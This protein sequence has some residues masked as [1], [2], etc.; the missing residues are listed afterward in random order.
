LQS[1]IWDLPLST[2]GEYSNPFI[3]EMVAL[4]ACITGSKTR[5]R[6]E[7]EGGEKV[8]EK[9]TREQVVRGLGTTKVVAWVVITCIFWI[10]IDLS[11]DSF[12]HLTL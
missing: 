6:G 3:W 1:I 2:A 7:E 8:E 4:L 11:E 5:E 9:G 10:N 12:I